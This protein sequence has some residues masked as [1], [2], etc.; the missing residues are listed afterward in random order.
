MFTVD[1]A[2]LLSC[3]SDL[4]IKLMDITKEIVVM[5]YSLTNTIT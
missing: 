3:A 1:G 5:S 4:T 2:M